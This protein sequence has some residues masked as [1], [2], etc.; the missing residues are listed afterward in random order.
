[1]YDDGAG[2]DLGRMLR[3][4]R[5][6]DR[7]TLYHLWEVVSTLGHGYMLNPTGTGRMRVRKAFAGITDLGKKDRRKMWKRF[8]KDYESLW[9][10]QSVERS[11][12]RLVGKRRL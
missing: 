3:S 7:Q 4:G 9:T 2:S 10:L 8:K 5:F 11:E 12:S 1:M 6:K